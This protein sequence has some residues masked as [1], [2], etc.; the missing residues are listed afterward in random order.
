MLIVLEAPLVREDK[1]KLGFEVL[2]VGLSARESSWR[3]H[4]HRLLVRG[5][6]G[7]LQSCEAL[8]QGCY[9]GQAVLGGIGS[10]HLLVAKLS[11]LGMVL[12]GDKVVEAP[13]TE[14]LEP[15]EDGL[16]LPDLCGEGR[17]ICGDRGDG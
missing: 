17:Q 5:M 11:H 14:A 9:S 13:A 7:V 16:A 8:C 2:E 3:S 6:G 12:D 1:G 15:S 10:G 4:F